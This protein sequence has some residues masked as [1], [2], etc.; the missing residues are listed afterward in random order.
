MGNIGSGLSA[1]KSG[2]ESTPLGPVIEAKVDLINKKLLLI[3]PETV[4][5]D[6]PTAL[7]FYTGKWLQY[8]ATELVFKTF[9]SGA[10]CATAF[11][12]ERDATSI[13]VVN[14]Q[15]NDE[16]LE[17]EQ[18]NGIGQFYKD[19][20][21]VLSVSFSPNDDFPN[22]SYDS[23]INY[24]IVGIG[25]AT[26]NFDWVVVTDPF[27]I[28]TFVLARDQASFDTYRPDIDAV[29]AA[30]K[31]DGKLGLGNLNS[32]VWEDRTHCPPELSEY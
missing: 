29:I 13:N 20:G 26:D 16:T 19:M 10:S 9:E 28:F 27:K 8:G 21:S 23:F 31:L 11:Y 3:A 5:V 30:N 15:L 14:K 4:D 22:P 12:T 6:V 25:P 1:I 18:I 24:L 17:I 32:I 2:L 7:E